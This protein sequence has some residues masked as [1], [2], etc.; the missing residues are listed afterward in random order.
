MVRYI[1]GRI[2]YSILVLLGIVTVIFLIFNIESLNP[3]RS[4]LGQRQD[5][6]LVEAITKDIGWDLPKGKRYLKYLNDLSPLSIHEKEVDS[7]Y[8]YF[9]EG[10][11]TSAVKL[12][13][14]GSKLWVLKAPYLRRSY[15]SQRLVTDVIGSALPV[16]A[17]LALVSML[18]ATILGIG[19]GVI[20]AIGK[21]TW[22]DRLSVIISIFGMSLPS[23]VA[24]ILMV[25]VFAYLLGEITGLP[26]TGSLYEVDEFEG[27]QIVWKNLI[28]P[29]LTLGIRPLAIVMQLTRSS[30]LD[31]LSQDYMRTAKAKGLSYKTI[32]FKH[33]L[34]NAL[35]PVVTAIS[36]WL[37]SLMAGAVFVEI[38]FGWNGIGNVLLDA[39]NTSDLPVV[40]GAVLVVSIIFVIINVLVD[41]IYGLIDPRVRLG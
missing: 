30:M 23:F 14:T 28:L 36:G 29:A 9:D 41:I 13:S 20:S 3:A 11:Y 7:H 18:I 19:L 8:L 6:A 15:Q 32:V 31:V 34:V 12:F 4:M 1:L 17:V 39:L 38:V 21:D 37:A 2:G 16:T 22:L 10:K 25:W 26:V 24:A 40:M 27:R 5:Q 35:N 33:G